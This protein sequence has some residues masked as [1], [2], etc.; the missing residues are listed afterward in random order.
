MDHENFWK[1]GQRSELADLADIR[2][3]HLSDILH[4][5]KE[6]G[7]AQAIMLEKMSG[8]VL[9]YPIPFKDWLFSKS[10]KHPAFFG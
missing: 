9:G 2:R 10:T 3:S 1:R 7:K 5:R 6:A 4:R 8:I